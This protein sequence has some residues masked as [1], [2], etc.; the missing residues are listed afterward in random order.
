MVGVLYPGEEKDAYNGLKLILNEKD[1]KFYEIIESTYDKDEIKEYSVEKCPK[2]L[3]EKY[4]EF[5]KYHNKIRQKI[6]NYENQSLS[7][8]SISSINTSKKD[9]N[10]EDNYGNK[11][12]KATSIRSSSSSI[13]N[14]INESSSENSFENSLGNLVGNSFGNSVG[15]SFGNSSQIKKKEPIVYIKK[16]YKDK[17]AKFLTL[18]NETKQIIF[19]DKAEILISEKDLVVGFKDRHGNISFIELGYAMKNS[20]KDFT[21]RLRYIKQVNYTQ[22]KKRMEE[23]MKNNKS[24]F[25]NNNTENDESKSN[26]SEL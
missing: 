1:E 10:D 26:Y 24:L 13:E 23:K 20:S 17:A 11:L 15:N 25:Q 5:L 3:K 2:R 21:K 12:D 19:K 7:S 6:C 22:I 4:D 14:S 16:F 8:E 9:N 18:S